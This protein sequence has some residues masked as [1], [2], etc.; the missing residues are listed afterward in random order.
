MLYLLVFESV[1][2]MDMFAYW[3]EKSFGKDV[4]IAGAMGMD[5][6]PREING[7]IGVVPLRYDAEGKQISTTVFP[8]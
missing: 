3:L 1:A 4:M 7:M 6:E 2:G 8:N 5:Y